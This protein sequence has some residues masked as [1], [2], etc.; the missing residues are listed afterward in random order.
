MSNVV[1]ELVAKLG[2]DSKE[3][4]S[5]M[6]KAKG[7]AG[8][9]G[10]AIGK[11]LKT[12]ATVGTAALGAASAAVT[13]FGVSSVKA[14]ADFDK[15]MS[16]VAATMGLSMDEMSEKVGSVDTAFGT[17]SGNLREYAQFMGSNTAFS[18]TQAADA[19]NYMA[20]A[21]YDAQTS[22]DMLPNV[23]NLA[24]A[25]NMDLAKASDMVTD[26]QTAFGIS[27]ERTAQMVDEMAK[28]SST[29]NTSVEQLGEAFLTVGGLAQEL[30]G[31]MVT[32]KD[33]TT[34][35]VDGVQ[36]LEIALTA[37]A[38]AGIKGSEAGTHMRNMLLKLA[39]PTS[40]GT[41]A[42]EAMGVE[43]FDAEGKMRSLADVFG[44]LSTELGGMTQEAKIS[45]ISDLFNTRDLASA[46]A[47]LNAVGSDWDKIGES[48]LDA[49]GS[50][51]KMADT[52]LDNLAGDVTLFKSALEGAQ[53]AVSDGLTPNLREFVQFGTTG[54]SRLTEA[55]KKGGVSGAMD[56]FGKILS[57]GVAMVV[58][59]IPEIVKAG[60]QLLKAFGQ[61]L[62][63]NSGLLVDTAMDLLG[64]FG[65]ALISNADALVSKIGGL[66]DSVMGFLSTNTAPFLEMA[67][68]FITTL[69]EGLVS[70]AP[71]FG[72]FVTDMLTQL[73]SFIGDNL[74]VMVSGA[75]SLITGLVNG[76]VQGLPQLIEEAA[77]L[78]INFALALTDPSNL[79]QMVESAI[80]LILA[81]A[82]GLINALPKLIEA[83]PKI[84]QN[85]ASAFIQNAPKLLA[86]GIQLLLMVYNGIVQTVPKL[87]MYV[88]QII[89]SLITGFAKGVAQFKETGMQF[90][91]GLWEGI[92]NSWD[93]LVQNVL[94]L[95]ETLLSSV[96]NLFGI[97]SPSRKFA[98]IGKFLDLGLAK[99]IKDNM[100][101]V[102]SAFDSLLSYTQNPVEIGDFSGSM[103][104]K[105]S[106]NNKVIGLLEQIANSNKNVTILL[107]GDAKRL[108]RAM[109]YEARK[110]KE[111]TG[112]PAFD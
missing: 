3:F 77:D 70:G 74:D 98:E 53:I 75:F 96:K 28:A 30:N 47:L 46:E 41:K 17:F 52:Q 104:V 31:G 35:S 57:D 56:E 72:S 15:S 16:Q 107:E 34:Q 7:I 29:G 39:S 23:L 99:G 84:V 111:I 91:S 42:L 89:K 12:V 27:L 103:D 8:S 86:A 55:F 92:S 54:L 6:G 76:L 45:T 106:Q 18:A 102:D 82:Q 79:N 101:A 80:N 69:G 88:P 64:Q 33:G 19:L 20:L 83:I 85:L 24:A 62:A 90:V 63:E 49:E 108:F 81:L 14:G 105:T 11:G 60:A 95:G 10:G 9:V 25:G 4:E 36:E 100:G 22:M 1:M 2:I 43:V 21:G 67:M 44:D 68:Q 61:G 110:N 65:D 5:G 51:Q 13:A 58:K 78:I 32:L 38:N 73:V 87:I 109:Q 26:T 48:I 37:M 59:K 112:Q 71:A 97:H 40:D 93:N 66:L 50:A 94:G